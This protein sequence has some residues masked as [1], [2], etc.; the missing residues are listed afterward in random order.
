M[1]LSVDHYPFFFLKMVIKDSHIKHFY[2]QF[3]QQKIHKF[4]YN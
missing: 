3:F 2:L 1:Y 4:V